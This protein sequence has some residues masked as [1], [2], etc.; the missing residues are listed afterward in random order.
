MPDPGEGEFFNTDHLHASLKTRALRGGVITIGTQATNFLLTLVSTAILARLLTPTDYGLVAMVAVIIGFV[1]MFKDFGLSMATVQRA[2]IT[3]S[4]VSALF[5]LNTALG[6]AL[7]TLTAA[8]APALAAF[9]EEPRLVPL[10][11][12]LAL[13]FL[14]SGLGVQH[15]ALLRRQMRYVSLAAV[16]I[17]ALV[18]AT[19]LALFAAWRGAHYW[20]LA[21]MMVA[22]AAVS[23]IGFWLFCGWRPS[24][25]RRRANIGAMLAFG[26]NLA[27]FNVI[28]YMARN[29]DQVLIGRVW[30]GG[31]L[32][33]YERA[34][35]LLHIS[36][37]LVYTPVSHVAIPVLSRLQHSPQLYREYYLKALYPLA[38]VMMPAAAFMSAMASDL[39]QVL[40]GSQWDQTGAIL[41]ALG[42]LG[43]LFPVSNTLG[44]HYIASGTTN[45]MLRWGLFDSA[46]VVT[47]VIVGVPYG[48]LGVAVAFSTA[49]VLL[50]LPGIWYATRTVPLG[51]SDILKTIRV[52][53]PSSVIIG[54]L[55]YLSRQTILAGFD[56]WSRLL[57]AFVAA[58][59]SYLAIACLASR[60]LAP[61]L[62]LPRLFGEVF[63]SADAENTKG[64]NS[65]S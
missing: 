63:R 8:F 20:A 60:S 54:T 50:F 16:E 22:T 12:F 13:T 35:R 27:G 61:L 26:S 37:K 34:S 51:V 17:S 14:I 11:R 53:L 65:G 30:G 47:A 1:A 3:Q 42:I 23:T 4:Q 25:P 6:L 36:L 57:I 29:I 59:V 24:S 10:T 56:T 21:L 7:T 33:A 40:M 49:R 58:A 44:W 43:L 28:N 19:I 5:W 46:A 18:A 41:S 9:Y 52:P 15:Q 64:R 32:G 31:E 45:R 38:F 2:E 55:L 62:D 48:G 39:I